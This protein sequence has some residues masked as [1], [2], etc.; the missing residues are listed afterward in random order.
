MV[1]A[2]T[3]EQARLLLEGI[4]KLVERLWWLAKDCSHFFPGL[5]STKTGYCSPLI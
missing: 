5:L 1:E 4:D 3:E 2:L